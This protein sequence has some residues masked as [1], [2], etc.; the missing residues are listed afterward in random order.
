MY[1]DW[2]LANSVNKLVHPVY[3]AARHSPSYCHGLFLD[4]AFVI[5]SEIY[6]EY[7]A[8]V[9]ILKVANRCTQIKMTMQIF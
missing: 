2:L 4:T 8:Q 1:Q 7:F 3:N 9:P 5:N 6:G